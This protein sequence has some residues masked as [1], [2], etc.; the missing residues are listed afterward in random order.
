MPEGSA[1]HFTLNVHKIEKTISTEKVME[2]LQ[3]RRDAPCT[4]VT[5]ENAR[6]FIFTTQFISGAFG[7][8]EACLLLV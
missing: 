1:I 3:K 7:T 6:R 8:V 4:S 2:N 5:S